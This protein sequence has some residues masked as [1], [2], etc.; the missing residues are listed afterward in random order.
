MIESKNS[1]YPLFTMQKATQMQRQ[2][3]M[4]LLSFYS[5]LC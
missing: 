2:R 4:E 5:S 3:E 1:P